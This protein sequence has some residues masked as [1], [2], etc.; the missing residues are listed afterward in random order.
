M[1]MLLLHTYLPTYPPTY[2]LI[3]YT[4]LLVPI[5]PATH[6]LITYYNLSNHPPTHLPMY[7]SF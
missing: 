2:L 7:V 5:Y 4:Y 3:I 6:M 1:G